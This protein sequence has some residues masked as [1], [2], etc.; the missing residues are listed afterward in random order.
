MDD[1]HSSPAL[2]EHLDAL[3][4]ARLLV[5]ESEV[6]LPRI[7]A[8]LGFSGLERFAEWFETHFGTLPAAV[9]SG[10]SFDLVDPIEDMLLCHARRNLIAPV[11]RQTA[12]RL[13]AVLRHRQ[14]LPQPAGA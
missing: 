12:E 10:K 7:A 6:S 9:R 8:A 3:E 1:R 14:P 13:L 11:D 4:I 2:H 5:R